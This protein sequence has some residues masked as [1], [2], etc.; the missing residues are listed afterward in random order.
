[1]TSTR[2]HT[3]RLA[4]AGG[5]F[6]LAAS[7]A[8]LHAQAGPQLAKAPRD[9]QPEVKRLVA[10]SPPPSSVA[11]RARAAA[12]VRAATAADSGPRPMKR[13][14][15]PVDSVRPAPEPVNTL[16]QSRAPAKA[17]PPPA[18]RA[19]TA[20]QPVAAR[21]ALVS[22]EPPQ[23]AT[24]RCKDGTF[25]TTAVDATSC[26][27]NGGLAVRILAARQLPKPPAP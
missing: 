16:D 26:T 7:A 4:A 27:D 23:G 9:T 8:A 5:A 21:A 14:S 18:P 3:F 17:P 15:P 10:P 2:S 25:L 12:Q 11:P 13:V 1:M 19:N 20:V 22:D 24:A 6:A